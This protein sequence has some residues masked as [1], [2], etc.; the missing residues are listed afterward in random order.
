MKIDIRPELYKS[1]IDKGL[2]PK[3]VI[4]KLLRQY[5]DIVDYRMIKSNYINQLSIT[6]DLT[7]E[8][9]S[10][11]N[12]LII[13]HGLDN[14]TREINIAHNKNS[15]FQDWDRKLKAILKF[16]PKCAYEWDKFKELQP[17]MAQ[18]LLDIDPDFNYTRYMHRARDYKYMNSRERLIVD[19]VDQLMIKTNKGK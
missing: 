4:E 15:Q 5:L 19:K 12:K 7:P 10:L 18:E 9:S 14:L 16:A 6:L 17:Q 3:Q 2:N 1:L 13:K 8:E 11:M